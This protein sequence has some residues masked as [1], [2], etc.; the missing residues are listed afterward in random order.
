MTDSDSE[1]ETTEPLRE[2]SDSELSEEEQ[3]LPPEK[4]SAIQSKKTSVTSKGQDAATRQSSV[5]EQQDQ[6][7]KAIEGVGGALFYTSRVKLNDVQSG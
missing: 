2:S 4:E 3:E 7:Q 1:G 6:Q 5:A